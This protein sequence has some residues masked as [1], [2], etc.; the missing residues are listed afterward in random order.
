MHNVFVCSSFVSQ[1]SWNK[2]INQ[3]KPV[4]GGKRLGRW[5]LSAVGS[6]YISKQAIDSPVPYTLFDISSPLVIWVSDEKDKRNAITET[7]FVLAPLWN[8]LVWCFVTV[9]MEMYTAYTASSLSTQHRSLCLQVDRKPCSRLYCRIPGVIYLL[10]ESLDSRKSNRNIHVLFGTPFQTRPSTFFYPFG[11]LPGITDRWIGEKWIALFI[12]SSTPFKS[13]TNA[14]PR[15]PEDGPCPKT[16][17]SGREPLVL[18]FCHYVNS[19]PNKGRFWR[20]YTGWGREGRSWAGRER[21][22]KNK[23]VISGPTTTHDETG[24]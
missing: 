18:F 19:S 10:F 23:A 22:A 20:A 7:A 6:S 24:K 2:L 1:W 21:K 3:S 5:K 11:G 16:Q 9:T 8:R 13:D 17:L 15:I 12:N 4:R 14:L